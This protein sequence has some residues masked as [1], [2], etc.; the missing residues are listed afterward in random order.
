MMNITS[1]HLHPERMISISPAARLFMEIDSSLAA[2]AKKQFDALGDKSIL[3]RESLF[4]QS[5]R[6][7]ISP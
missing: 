2:T 7:L 6:T 4:S 3:K 1:I 5:V